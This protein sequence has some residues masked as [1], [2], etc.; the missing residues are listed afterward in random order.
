VKTK[1]FWRQFLSAILANLHFAFI[2]FTT[3]PKRRALTTVVG[4]PIRVSRVDGEPSQEQIDELHEVYINE[5]THLF[6]QHKEK[7]LNDK[8]IKLEII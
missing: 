1:S 4:K 5:L 2:I 3:L 8:E 7:Y 6:E